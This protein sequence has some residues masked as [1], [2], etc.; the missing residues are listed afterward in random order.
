[1]LNSFSLFINFKSKKPVQSLPP[2]V[3]N[4]DFASA[5]IHY[6]FLDFKIVSAFQ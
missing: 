5:E 6:K 2:L 3:E 4:E 1:M